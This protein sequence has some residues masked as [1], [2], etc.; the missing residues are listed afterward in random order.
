MAGGMCGQ[1]GMCGRGHAW[2]G[3]CIGRGGVHAM[4]PPPGHYEIWS[5]NVRAVRILPECILVDH[6]SQKWI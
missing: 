2:Q 1:G 6:V 3:A 5:V 4:H